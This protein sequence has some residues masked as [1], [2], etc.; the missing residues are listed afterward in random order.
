[1]ALKQMMKFTENVAK[2]CEK[3][4]NTG[5]QAIYGRFVSETAN[6]LKDRLKWGIDNGRNIDGNPFRKADPNPTNSVTIALRDSKIKP[7]QSSNTPILHGTGALRES[8]VVSHRGKPGNGE[9]FLVKDKVYSSYGKFHN[10]G[11]T[12]GSGSLVPNANVPQ[13]KYWGIPKSFRA[14]NGT[15]YKRLMAELASNLRFHFGKFLDTGQIGTVAAGV[16]EDIAKR[17][18][19]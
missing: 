17:K 2:A 14:P 19:K 12:T 11:F 18:R 3:L 16:Y 15:V 9:L 6:A 10:S 13:R 5:D 4:S 7:R 8:F 1:M